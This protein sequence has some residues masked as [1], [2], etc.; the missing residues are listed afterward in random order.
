MLQLLFLICI[1]HHTFVFGT[2]LANMKEMD[3]VKSSKDIN[4]NGDVCTDSRKIIWRTLLDKS[5]CQNNYKKRYMEEIYLDQNRKNETLSKKEIIKFFFRKYKSF[6][7][8][9]GHDGNLGL[10][11]LKDKMK[12]LLKMSLNEAD[13]FN[14]LSL[15][16]KEMSA[17][18][19]SKIGMSKNILESKPLLKMKNK[20]LNDKSH[21]FMMRVN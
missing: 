11:I 7:T 12:T 8:I 3:L 17:K 5:R 14:E 6:D 9:D 20:K 2:F 18:E 10:R 16:K 21:S 13:I 19:K 1:L 4:E 15:R